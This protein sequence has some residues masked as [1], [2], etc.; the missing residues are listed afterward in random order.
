[1]VKEIIGNFDPAGKFHGSLLKMSLT[2]TNWEL[3]EGGWG[4]DIKMMISLIKY[5]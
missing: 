4:I 3:Y 5:G 1:M 2:L